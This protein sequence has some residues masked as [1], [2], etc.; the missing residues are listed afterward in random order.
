[1]LSFPR[2]MK[3]ASCYSIGGG[4]DSRRTNGSH[5]GPW[6]FRSA[7]S[8]LHDTRP[9]T[10]PRET[11]PFP[12]A[13]PYVVARYRFGGVGGGLLPLPCNRGAC[14]GPGIASMSLKAD[15]QGTW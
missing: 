4:E 2:D 15:S 7:R 6:P 13:A 14:Q 5:A 12:E 1:M 8:R 3:M 10:E 9:A 11:G